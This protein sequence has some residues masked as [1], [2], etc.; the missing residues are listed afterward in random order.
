MIPNNYILNSDYLALANVS[1]N[2]FTVNAAGG[3]VS[4]NIPTQTYNFTVPATTSVIDR[5]QVSYGGQTVAGTDTHIKISSNATVGVQVYR[6]T[7]TNIRVNLSFFPYAAAS[8]SWSAFTL[9]IHVDSFA[10]LNL[11]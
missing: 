9:N 5:V 4:G 3:T 8:G 2:D 1:S 7:A 11:T 6:T 10:P